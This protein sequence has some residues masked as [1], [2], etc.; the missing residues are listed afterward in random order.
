MNSAEFVRVMNGY[1][2]DFQKLSFEQLDK[3]NI[4]TRHKVASK[5]CSYIL[6]NL[7]FFFSVAS[8][9]S[10]QVYKA[11]NKRVS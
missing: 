7:D 1:I 6:E 11:K 8:F 3:D 5:M 10:I 4:Y 2:E 9:R